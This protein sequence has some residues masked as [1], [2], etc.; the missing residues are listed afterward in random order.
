[1]NMTIVIMIVDAEDVAASGVFAYSALI[2][3]PYLFHDLSP[4]TRSDNGAYPQSI[5]S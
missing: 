4:F 3:G 2:G 1:M 5:R